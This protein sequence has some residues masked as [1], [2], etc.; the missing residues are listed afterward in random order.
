MSGEQYAPVRDL[1]IDLSYEIARKKGVLNYKKFLQDYQEL[2]DKYPA[3]HY[4]KQIVALRTRKIFKKRYHIDKV[5]PFLKRYSLDQKR[6]YSDFI[7]NMAESLS[8][9]TKQCIEQII[10]DIRGD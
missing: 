8:L 4:L 1:F 10:A 3:H 7:T 9:G 5:K 2:I 6:L